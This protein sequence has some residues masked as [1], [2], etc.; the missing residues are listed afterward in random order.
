[1][2]P[3]LLVLLISIAYAAP[4]S[5]SVWQVGDSIKIDQGYNPQAHVTASLDDQ[6]QETGWATLKIQAH[7]SME[8]NPILSK[9]MGVAEGYLT[10]E[11]I[12][13]HTTNFD[14]VFGLYGHDISKIRKAAIDLILENYWYICKSIKENPTDPFWQEVKFSV[15]QVT[16][17]LEGM[18]RSGTH[19][20]DLDDLLLLNAMG[21]IM[22][23]VQWKGPHGFKP[24]IPP[25]NDNPL[26]SIG[27][28]HKGRACPS[29]YHLRFLSIHD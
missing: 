5:V 1:M 12:V 25:D 27:Q 24:T 15:D 13:N 4:V 8:S 18:H 9:L 20:V 21:D 16:G 19:A 17:I 10:S 28:D 3:L 14:Y 7:P 11:L 22:D 26:Y 23:L 29:S 2:L 6:R